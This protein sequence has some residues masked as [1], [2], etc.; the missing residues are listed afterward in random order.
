[1]VRGEFGDLLGTAFDD[2]LTESSGGRTVLTARIRDDQH[3][4]GIMDR[5]RDLGIHIISLGEVAE[6]RD[7]P[8]EPSQSSQ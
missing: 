7:T 8:E 4:Y 5:L 2:V 6:G 1:V 3:L